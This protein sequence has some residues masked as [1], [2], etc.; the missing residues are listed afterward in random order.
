MNFYGLEDN[1]YNFHT[2]ISAYID[3]NLVSDTNKNNNNNNINISIDLNKIN[4]FNLKYII[5]ELGENKYFIYEE[6][7]MDIKEDIFK[8]FDYL[9]YGLYLI[10]YIIM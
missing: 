3:N 9:F 6:D 10:Y 8:I 5:H 4:K 7:N 1:K 2:H